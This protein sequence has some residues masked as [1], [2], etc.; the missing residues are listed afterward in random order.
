L[1]GVLA[2]WPLLDPTHHRV[3]G[4]VWKAAYVMAARVV[5]GVLGILITVFPRQ[6]YTFYGSRPQAYELGDVASRVITDQRIAGGMMMMVDSAVILIGV[7]YFLV[8]TERGKEHDDDLPESVRQG[9]IDQHDAA[10]GAGSGA[11]APS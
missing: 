4:R 7:T 9:Y 6:I 8:T 5:G 10:S 1:T 11:G 2:Y 3:E